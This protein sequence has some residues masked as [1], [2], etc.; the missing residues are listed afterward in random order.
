MAGGEE[1][2]CYIGELRNAGIE[3]ILRNLG[4]GF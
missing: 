1:S 2:Y 3:T 4:S